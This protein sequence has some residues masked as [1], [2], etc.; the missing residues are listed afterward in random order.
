MPDDSARLA[1]RP[2]FNARMWR[3]IG[4]LL[5]NLPMGILG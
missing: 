5:L 2:G 4:Y 3:E 1:T